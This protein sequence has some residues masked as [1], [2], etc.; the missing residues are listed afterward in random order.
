MSKSTSLDFS[1]VGR[2]ALMSGACRGI[3]G[4]G[5]LSLAN[6]GADVAIA[7]QTRTE[8]SLRKLPPR[9]VLW[10]VAKQ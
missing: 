3:G 8:A 6:A 10:D 4:G 9:S 5:A 2:I 1:I 7:E